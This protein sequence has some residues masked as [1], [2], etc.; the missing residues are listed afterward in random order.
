MIKTILLLLYVHGFPMNNKH[1]L[2]QSIQILVSP[3]PPWFK[4][5]PPQVHKNKGKSAQVTERSTHKMC[6]NSKDD[7]PRQ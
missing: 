1:G 4:P 6:V 2:F 3:T 7:F 5:R